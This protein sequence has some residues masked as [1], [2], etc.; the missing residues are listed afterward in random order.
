MAEQVCVPVEVVTKKP[1]SLTMLESACLPIAAMTALQ[2]LR[3]YGAIKPGERVLITG[4]G[5]CVGSMA[6][7]IA[8]AYGCHVT[9]VCRGKHA[10]MVSQAGAD[11]VV[12]FERDD[13]LTLGQTWDCVFDAACYRPIR[14]TMG[15][16]NDNGRFVH[17]GGAG[18]GSIMRSLFLKPFYSWFTSKQIQIFVQTCNVPDLR[19]LVQ[20]CDAGKLKPCVTRTVTMDGVAGAMD[21][22]ENHKTFGKVGVAIIA[23]DEE[24]SALSSDDEDVRR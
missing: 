15:V 11:I 22:F 12:D 17:V 6:V 8:K 4:A 10:A 7:Q 2:G 9:A 5:G 20:L 19:E 23:D 3:D 21:D 1:K 13:Y 18:M 14:S 16:L 24:Q